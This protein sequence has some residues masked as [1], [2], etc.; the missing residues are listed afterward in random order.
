MRNTGKTQRIQIRIH[1]KKGQIDGVMEIIT[2]LLAISNVL[3]GKAEYR[4]D[5]QPGESYIYLDLDITPP[6]LGNL[7]ESDLPEYKGDNP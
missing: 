7:G 5:G 1:G 4:R 6:P 3:R 2:G